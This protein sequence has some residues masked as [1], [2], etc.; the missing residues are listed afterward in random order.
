MQNNAFFVKFTLRKQ[1]AKKNCVFLNFILKIKF[2]LN[3][4]LSLTKNL[5][6][7]KSPQ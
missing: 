7:V 1:L 6:L 4:K 5:S 3:L 2:L